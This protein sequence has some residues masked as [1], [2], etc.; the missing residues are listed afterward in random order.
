MNLQQANTALG[1]ITGTG[2]SLPWQ[3]ANLAS[4]VKSTYAM[5]DTKGGDVPV[6]KS[7]ANMADAISSINPPEE[8]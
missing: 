8:I 1:A 4:E 7:V 5:V 3:I 6:A 2:G